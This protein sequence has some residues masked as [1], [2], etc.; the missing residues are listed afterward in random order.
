M[1]NDVPAPMM[2]WLSK[3][4]SQNIGTL[5]A[6]IKTPFL[7]IYTEHKVPLW[8]QVCDGQDHRSS[9]ENMLYNYWPNHGKG[10][11]YVSWRA[12]PDH[13]EAN[14]YPRKGIVEKARPYDGLSYWQRTQANPEAAK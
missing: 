7:P 3:L 5:Y 12:E 1:N 4:P 2:D 14:T 13:P 9:V 6:I 10:F 11:T 8:G